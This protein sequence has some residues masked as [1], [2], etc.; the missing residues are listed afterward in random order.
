MAT[1]AQIN[2][3]LKN[4]ASSTGP[5]TPSGKNAS[6]QNSCRHGL[7]GTGGVV[8]PE[9]R[10]KVEA[11][12]AALREEFQPESEFERSLVEQMAVD[13]IRMDRCRES[14]LSLSQVQASRAELCW[15]EDKRAEAEEIASRLGWDPARSRSKLEQSRHGCELLIDR[16]EGLGRVLC[17]VGN[18]DDAQRSMALNL[19]GVPIELRVGTTAVD[20]PESGT[21]DAK[22]FRLG[23]VEGELKRLRSRK[24]EAFDRLDDHDRESVKAGIGAELSKPLRLLERYESACFRRQQAALRILN[25]RPR[26][27]EPISTRPVAQRRPVAEPRPAPQAPQPPDD[28]EIDWS[29]KLRGSKP[30]SS[31]S[32][33]ELMAFYE[34]P[35]IDPAP[36]QPR[37]PVYAVPPSRR[38]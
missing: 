31:M 14:Y 16:W 13:S 37:T 26:P 5:R 24:A 11:R 36:S 10:A 9:D 19:L 7:A 32:L 17:E 33:D 34:T 21:R 20:T 18:W 8:C 22:A 12:A 28:D 3:N 1:E 29:A 23:L 30:L 38:T 27:A 4:S 15:D 6:R 25:D 2:S 35:P